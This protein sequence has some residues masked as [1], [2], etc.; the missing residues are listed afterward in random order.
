MSIEWAKNIEW[1]VHTPDKQI[2]LMRDHNWAFAAWEIARLEGKIGEKS[3]VVH[4]DSHF[5]E[6]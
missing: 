4:V 5:D 1:R 3:L 2:F 6:I